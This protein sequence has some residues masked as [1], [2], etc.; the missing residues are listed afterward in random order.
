MRTLVAPNSDR[1]FI[2]PRV[3]LP[4][5]EQLSRILQQATYNFVHVAY[6]A[7]DALP[8][9]YCRC[10]HLSSQTNIYLSFPNSVGQHASLFVFFV[11]FSNLG[12]Y[13]DGSAIPNITKSQGCTLGIDSRKVNR[14]CNKQKPAVTGNEKFR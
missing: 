8:F 13:A 6:Q 4:K 2:F 5:R 10:S 9:N 14:T 11:F 7:L 3:K 1:Q 12:R